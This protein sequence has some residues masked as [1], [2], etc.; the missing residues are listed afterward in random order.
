M[1]NQTLHRYKI[2]SVA[3]N[4]A[5]DLSVITLY[6]DHQQARNCISTIIHWTKNRAK[7]I[8]KKLI[9]CLLSRYLLEKKKKRKI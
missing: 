9:Y 1:L 7:N 5:Y 3:Q 8:K 6:K 4:L 2:F